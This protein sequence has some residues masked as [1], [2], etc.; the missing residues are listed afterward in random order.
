M[1]LMKNAYGIEIKSILD[2]RPAVTLLNPEKQDLHSVIALELGVLLEH[3]AKF[4]K[5]NW[6][7][8]PISPEAIEYALNDVNYLFS[9]KEVLFNKLIENKLIDSFMLSNLKIQN[10][11]YT[12]N[13]RDKY[14]RTSSYHKL[15]TDEKQ[16]VHKLGK[17]IEKYASENNIPSHWIINKNDVVEIVKDPEFLDNIQLPNQLSRDSMVSILSELKSAATRNN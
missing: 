17:I 7:K 15:S 10:K 6:T 4:H 3:K 14:T 12:R 2:L 1:S 11:D 5:Y 13:L 9:L 16:I 8:R